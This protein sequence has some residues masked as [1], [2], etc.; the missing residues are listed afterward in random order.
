MIIVN[1]HSPIKLDEKGVMTISKEQVSSWVRNF[2]PLSP[3]ANSRWPTEAGIYEPLF[4]FNSITNKTV[5]WLGTNYT[6]KLNNR[7]LEIEI[8]DNVQWSDGNPFS[9][10]DVEFTFQLK[11]DFPALDSRGSWKYLNSV[12][13]IDSSLIQFEFSKLFVPGFEAIGGQPIVPKHI[14]KNIDDPIKFSNPLPVGT[15]PFTEIIK[16]T[17]QLWELGKNPYYWKKDKPKINKLRFPAFPT[18]EQATLAIINDEVDWAGNFI[19]AID[20]IYVKKDTLHHKYWFPKSGGSVFLYLNTTIKP[21]DNSNV[22]KAISM[23][24]DRELIVKVAMYNYTEPAHQTALSGGLAFWRIPENEIIEN[25]VDYNPEKSI[26]IL[27]NEGLIKNNNGHWEN[28]D[29]TPINIKINIV[30]GWS[31]WIRAGQIIAKNLNEIGFN[32]KIITAGFG[33]WFSDLQTGRFSMAI[34]WANKGETPFPMYEGLLA[35]K[36]VVPVGEVANIN[37]QRFS[38]KKMDDLIIKFEE[39]SDKVIIY[40]IINQMQKIFIEYAPAIPL[41]AEPTWGV[42]NTLRFKNFPSKVNPYAQISP[43]NIPENL[44]ILTEVIPR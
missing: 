9:A 12:N 10:F 24:I 33:S 32:A 15:G 16:F 7:V 44:F 2:N 25:W 5:P 22:R 23:A 20:R 17:N 38:N 37:W 31:D 11:K 26:Q 4:I 28:P 1:C 43:N 35:S 41:F 36:Y 14:W 29:G 34:A 6:W 40:N 19:P 21:F 3:G 13:V 30:S 42:Y 39:N 27:N 18:N 8:R